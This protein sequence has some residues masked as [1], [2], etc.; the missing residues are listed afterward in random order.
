MP[1]PAISAEP[2]P[3]ATERAINVTT[4]VTQWAAHRRLQNG[5]LEYIFTL[6]RVTGTTRP[7]EPLIELESILKDQELTFPLRLFTL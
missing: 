2:S 7:K 6:L 5:G 4:A 1:R 3:S